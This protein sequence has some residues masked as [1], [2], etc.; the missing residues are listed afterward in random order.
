TR[1][2]EW[3]G[4]AWFRRS[5]PHKYGRPWMAGVCSRVCQRFKPGRVFECL[6]G[7]PF[8]GGI[9][10]Q[11]AQVV[12]V[13]PVILRFRFLRAHVRFVHLDRIEKTLPRT[14]IVARPIKDMSRHVHH[15]AGTR[16]TGTWRSPGLASP[17]PGMPATPQN[18]WRPGAQVMPSCA[19]T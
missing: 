4:A 1:R 5:E 2:T 11:I 6:S 18:L 14:L 12:G 16:P 19:R 15:V 7:P 17:L 9:G 13:I 10:D 3:Q 8:L